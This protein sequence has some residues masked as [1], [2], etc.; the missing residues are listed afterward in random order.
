M[1][2]HI[3][4]PLDG[5]N[6]A[7]SVLP[8]AVKLAELG[9]KIT[10][11]HV[12]ERNAPKEIHGQR[13]LN[14]ED[15]AYEYLAD[16]SSN[17]FPDNHEVDFHVHSSEV[18]DVAK[19]IVDHSFELGVDLV[20]MCTHGQGGLRTL[21]FGSIAQQIVA[22]GRSPVLLIHPSENGTAL[23]IN[24]KKFLIPLD[25]NPDHES[26]FHIAASLAESCQALLH[27]V[28]VIYTYASL[29][30]ER[31]AS[32]RLL[33]GV[34]RAILDIS[35]HKAIGYL[36]EKARELEDQDLTIT[37]EVRQGNPATVIID[38]AQITG[39]DLIVM[40]THGKTS[41]NA[42]WSDSITAKISSK[43]KLPL[44]LVPVAE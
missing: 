11:L 28:M 19:S 29:P 35:S 24:C 44:L 38:A 37:T 23:N 30:G 1:F 26:G 3:L 15:E 6:L 33:P 36:Q 20:A 32:A 13:H 17:F 42:F 18:S 25:G 40:G 9:A 5:S 41:L 39:A 31:A 7:Q 22:L 4:V 27:L 43:T 8:S 34:T 12:I 21:L 10:L 14:N 2:K 16:I